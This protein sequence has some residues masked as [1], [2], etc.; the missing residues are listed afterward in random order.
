VQNEKSTKE[1]LLKDAE[2]MTC[3]KLLNIG[4]DVFAAL[5]F[6]VVLMKVEKNM[7]QY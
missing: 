1:C 7:R 3:W 6:L 2:R 5:L 4:G